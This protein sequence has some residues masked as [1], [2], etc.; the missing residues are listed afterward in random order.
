MLKKDH[1]CVCICTYKRP[2]RLGRLLQKLAKQDTD[3]LFT[4][5][6]VIVDN[7]WLMSARETVES[8]SSKSNIEVSYFVETR[9]N[10]ALA[11]NKAIENAK[12]N[13]VSFIDDDE[14]PDLRWLLNLYRAIHRYN[15]N[16]VLGPVLPYFEKA[17][18]K[19]IIRGRFFE[20]PI[21]TNGYILEW[22]NT[23]TGN[24][25]LRR[26]LFKEDPEW[27]RPEFGSGGEDRDFFRRMIARGNV[28]VWCNEAKVFELVPSERWEKRILMKRAL[29]RGKMALRYAKPW[30]ISVFISIAAIC[31]YSLG[32]PYL[33]FL[34]PIFGYEVFMKYLVKCCDHL[35]K[36]FAFFSIDL[37]SDKYIN[38]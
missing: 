12:G 38:P 5:S 37:I 23:R 8:Y 14:L 21:H 27:F 19:W 28:F 25:L 24:V 3:D 2:E 20:R 10:I 34:S 15:S 33:F 17:P 9:Q 6:L 32:M 36:I 22:K 1:I 29:M 4:Y 7:D 18:P 35:G 13:F 26:N 31:T 30:P 11:R 16:G